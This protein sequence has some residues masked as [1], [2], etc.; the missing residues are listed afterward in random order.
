MQIHELPVGSIGDTN[1]L[2]FDTGANTYSVSFANLATYIRD[3]LNSLTFSS[4]NTSSKTLPGAVN[5]LNTIGTIVYGT[6]SGQVSV[7]TSADANVGSVNLSSAGKWLVIACGDW[8]AN[9][10]GYR[11]ISIDVSGVNPNRN[12]A[13]T[14]MAATESGK[15]TFQQ[16]MLIVATTQAQT[17]QIY[18]RQ[19]SGSSVVIYPYVYAI[20]IGN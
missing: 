19:N 15:Y 1:K 6:T 7:I 16:A 5:E 4:L 9:A 11:Q 17:V 2:P 20:K 3:K 13:V 12:A 10:T 8:A 18:A 14:T